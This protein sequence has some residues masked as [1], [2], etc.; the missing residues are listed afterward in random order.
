MEQIKRSKFIAK[1]FLPSIKELE[2][3]IPI[4]EPFKGMLKTD[5]KGFERLYEDRGSSYFRTSI[6]RGIEIMKY[7]EQYSGHER[8]H[9]IV[10]PAVGK[11]QLTGNSKL[12]YIKIDGKNYVILNTPYNA[13]R[14]LK[15]NN[16]KIL[17][18]DCSIDKEGNI[19]ETYLDGED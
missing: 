10:I 18:E 17:P 13:E 4:E 19:I 11:V 2:K 12:K 5:I 15:V 1:Q 3:N 6:Q 8:P 9:Y 16:L 14:F 7:L